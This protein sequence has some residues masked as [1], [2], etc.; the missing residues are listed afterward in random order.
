M[1]SPRRIL[2]VDDDAE[3][4]GLTRMVLEDAGYQIEEAADGLAALTR[5]GDEARALDLVLLD[6][7]MPGM[8]G[9]ELL[10]ILRSDP[11]LAAVPVVLFTVKSEI[12]DRVHGLQDGAVD[13]VTKPFRIDDLVARVDRVFREIEGGV[14][15]RSS[16]P[17]GS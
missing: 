3:I 12:R 17:A 9:W 15:P 10:R 5:L 16:I 11:R 2:L 14:T 13:Y 8:S 4:R 6:V 1:T 7:N